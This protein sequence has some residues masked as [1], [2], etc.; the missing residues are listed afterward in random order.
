MISVIIPTLNEAGVL[1]RTLQ[2]LGSEIE[3]IEVLC[4][5]GG[6][7]DDTVAVAEAHG[8]RVIR[9]ARGRGAQQHVGA[10]QAG[11]HV[12]WFLHADTV[13]SPGAVKQLQS[14][15]KA[16][17]GG[18]VA[19][20]F[21]LVFDGRSGGARFLNWLY[22]HLAWLGLRYGDSGIWVRR[23][24]YKRAGG[25]RPIPIFEDLDLLRRVRRYGHLR[26]LPGPL[27]T[28]SRRFESKPFAGVFAQWVGLQVLYWCGGDP[29]WLGRKYYPSRANGARDH[30][31]RAP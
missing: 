29:E 17:D 22:P 27:T 24:I 19:G 3:E 12:F 30:R 9:A 16:D 25:F 14:I 21:R 26:T 7:V 1:G 31:E 8:A 13:P 28:S 2:A 18:V 11:G 23:E 6:S 20:N 4:V 15:V 10:M 5:D